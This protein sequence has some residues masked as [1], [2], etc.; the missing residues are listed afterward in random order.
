MSNEGTFLEIGATTD[1]RYELI[2]KVV[3]KQLSYRDHQSRGKEWN[4]T[5]QVI[6]LVPETTSESSAFFTAWLP[7]DGA[8]KV[9]E[10]GKKVIEY[11]EVGMRGSYPVSGFFRGALYRANQLLP[12]PHIFV[13]SKRVEDLLQHCIGKKIR[14]TVLGEEEFD[15]AYEAKAET[16]SPYGDVP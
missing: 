1:E 14:L 10:N 15:E 3:R 12:Q 6:L 16:K 4:D 2:C 13:M 5:A 9:D 11:A 7:P 8:T